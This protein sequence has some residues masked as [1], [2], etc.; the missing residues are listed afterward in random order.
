MPYCTYCGT[1]LSPQAVN[2]PFCG[3][4]QYKPKNGLTL[5]FFC[6]FFG[7][8]GIHRFYAGRVFSGL[9]MLFT[10]G[11]FGIWPFVDIV[12]ILSGDFT[13]INGNIIKVDNKALA[14]FF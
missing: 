12:S 2:C 3:H 10:F 4:P 7:G 14:Q 8:L 6:L 9:I 1:N 11:G 13:D 5:F